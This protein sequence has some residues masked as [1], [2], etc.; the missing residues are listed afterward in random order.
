MEDGK[1]A[2]EQML[3]KEYGDLNYIYRSTGKKVG[4]SAAGNIGLGLADG[5]YINFLDDDDALLPNHV[6]ILVQKLLSDQNLAAYSVAE[7]RLVADQKIK[8]KFIRF[9]QPFNRILLY[10]FNYISIQSIMFHRSLFEKLGGL[11]ETLETLEDWDLWIRYST[12]TSFSFVDQVTSY[13]H[14]P[15]GRS[16]KKQRASQLKDYLTPLHAKFQTYRL[17]VSVEELNQEMQYVVREYKN[18][19]L[20]RYLRMFFRVVFLGER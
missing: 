5:E 20:M 15:Y 16:E 8:K 6:R 10:T 11:D 4:R 1:N 18:K 12:A 17:E 19:G 7:E 2:A 14:T 9:R 13:Y 3:A